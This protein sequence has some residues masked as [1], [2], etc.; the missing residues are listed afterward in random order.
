MKP[1]P[2]DKIAL[3]EEAT[4][5]GLLGS[6][7]SLEKPRAKLL[8]CIYSSTKIHRSFNHVSILLVGPTGVGKSATIN[9]L[10]GVDLATTSRTESNTRSTNEFI[11]HGNDPNYEVEGLSLG[12]VDTPGFCDTDGTM[13]DACNLLSMQKFF[14]THPTLSGC[15]PNLIFLILKA[16]DNRMEGKN[17]ELGKSLRCI[18]QLGLVDLKNPN[19]VAIL[20]HACS[21]PHGNVKEWTVKLNEVKSNVSKLVFNCLQVSAPVVAIENN[22]K[23]WNL[24]RRDD[25]TCL[26]NKDWQPKNLYV[27]CASL[28]EYN[29]DSLGLI[30]L[31]SIFLESEQVPK[32]VPISGHETEAKNANQFTLDS[33]E[34]AMVKKLKWMPEVRI[35]FT[36]F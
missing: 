35:M 24:K 33:E 22:Y 2:R 17:S 14:R 10:L 11:V 20:T 23:G 9:H 5:L 8:E 36:S 3:L 7:P 6:N 31:N 12:L 28:L 29:K 30:T 19:V 16:T 26:L 4:S 32:R 25:Y 15:Y 18:K 13:Q 27:A 21:I 34:K 1:F